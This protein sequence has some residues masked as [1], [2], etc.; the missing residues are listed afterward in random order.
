MRSVHVH[1]AVRKRTGNVNSRKAT[2]AFAHPRDIGNSEAAIQLRYVQHRIH[3]AFVERIRK[4]TAGCACATCSQQLQTED[5]F[6]DR[7]LR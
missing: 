2:I 5:Q 7:E 6:P 1:F 4:Q 3:I